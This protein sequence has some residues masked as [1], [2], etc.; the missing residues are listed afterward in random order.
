M[1]KRV[2]HQA[3]VSGPANVAVALEVAHELHTPDPSP[4]LPELPSPA[5]QLMG[6]R[7]SAARPHRRKVPLNRL[8]A[9]TRLTPAGV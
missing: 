3:P 8:T 9:L 7:T 6:L 4:R 5:P 1:I 2:S